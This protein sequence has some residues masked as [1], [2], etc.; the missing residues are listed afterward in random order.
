[1]PGIITIR[2]QR[3]DANKQFNIKILKIEIYERND[4]LMRMTKKIT[5]I[6]LA[7]MMVVSMMSVMAVTANAAVGDYVAEEDYLTFTALQDNSS[8]MLSNVRSGSDFQY[9][10]NGTWHDYDPYDYD[11]IE[12]NKGEY[13]RFRGSNTVSHSSIACFSIGGK[14][15]ASG[16]IM[17]LRLDSESRSQGLTNECFI[18]LFA[19]CKGLITAPEL[20]EKT[21]VYE[22]YDAMFEGCSNL[23]TAPELP[24]TTLAYGCYADMFMGCTSLTEA[25]ALPATTLADA[26]Y[27]SMFS[28]CT[29][30]TELPE[31]PAKTLTQYCYRNMFYGCSSIRISDEPVTDNGIKYSKAYSIPTEGTATNAY[32]AV[33]AMFGA[34]GGKFKGT[35]SLN[36]TYYIGKPVY[37]VKW[38]NGDNVI[39]EDTGVESG[40]TPTFNGTTPEKAEDEN[41][42]YEFSG[43]SDGNT[44]YGLSDTL[45]NVTA[46]VTYTAQFT[47]VPKPKKLTLNVGE[48]GKVVM[49]NGTFGNATDAS[50]IVE[51]QGP[52]DVADETKVSIVEG[53]SLNLVEGGSVN[54]A[55]GGEVSLYPSADNTG[56][57]TAIPAEGYVFA[58]WYNGDTLY[59]SDAALSYQNI[60]E[61]ITLTASFTAHDPHSFENDP[62]FNWTQDA[63]TGDWKA[64]K[65]TLSCECGATKDYTL[66]LLGVTT[67]ANA[68]GTFT[69]TATHKVGDVTYTDSKVNNANGVIM[70]NTQLRLAAA[71]GGEWTLGADVTKVVAGVVADG[72]VLN[73]GGHKVTAQTSTN[74]GSALFKPVD[75]DSSFTLNNVI[76]D[77]GNKRYHAV[78]SYTRDSNN[79]GN[80]IVL[81]G[82]TVQNFKSGDYA[83]A[84]YAY[85]SATIELNDCTVT[86]NAN[87]TTAT[88]AANSGKD[89][90]AG[91]K[92]TIILNDGEYGE[93]LLHGG[94]ANVTIDGGAVVDTVRFGYTNAG[95]DSSKM[96]ATV[97]DGTVGEFASYTDFVAENIVIDPDNATVPTPEGYVWTFSKEAGKKT[98]VPADETNPLLAKAE[99]IGYQR[100]VIKTEQS[101]AES[102]N[103]IGT[104]GVRIVTQIDQAW[105]DANA[106]DYGY[107]V[108]KITSDKTQSELNF[109]ALKKDGGNGEKTI[110]CKNT[111]NNGVGYGDG[112]VTLAVN[113]MTDNDKVVARFYVVKDGVTYYANYSTYTGILAEYTE[114]SNG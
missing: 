114:V 43:W 44:T 52:I 91:A 4:F 28:G 83:G 63:S 72:F 39:E 94:T 54:I 2:G 11:R 47:A 38:K 30:L 87:K 12:L 13:V 79:S 93:V 6:V 105:L 86:G 20:P 33:N 10:K 80:H 9:Y 103:D 40:A 109:N 74:L 98:L 102:G 60:S 81:N 36:T 90:W 53:H 70:T 34:T 67:T 68:D 112:Y 15:A 69:Y 75:A 22:C 89:I 18:N 76:L 45:P 62:T 58:G 26:C 111:Y 107:V 101:T 1:M 19:G 100:K 7:V 32:G 31:L 65:L 35:P 57:I 96:Q 46:D 78:S 5:S 50:N 108:A 48:N 106:S 113:G 66:G 97:E 37:T 41:N 110:S 61:N 14:V 92:A 84:V 95:E 59:S 25:P 51:V 64:T 82:V 56:V 99:I 8:V 71:A 21:L 104:K 77:G 73:G 85:G 23:T 27:N 42:T 49:D 3:V 17:S 29:S 88:T 16:N 24:A 55:T